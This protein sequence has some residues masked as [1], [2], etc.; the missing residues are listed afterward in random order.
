MF[1]TSLDIL[2]I[3]L[4]VGLG[5]LLIS[6]SVLTIRVIGTVNRINKITDIVEDSADTVNTYIQMPASL[7]A[8]AISAFKQ[9]KD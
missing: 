1:N 3:V 2:Y 7:F 8:T 4:A 6:L 9:W 5:V